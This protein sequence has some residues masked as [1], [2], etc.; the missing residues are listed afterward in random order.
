MSQREHI[1]ENA[2]VMIAGG[3]YRGDVADYAQQV[4]NE[5][6]AAPDQPSAAPEVCVWTRPPE[7]T[8]MEW[9][10][11][12][13]SCGR[14]DLAVDYFGHTH[15]GYCGKPKSFLATDPTSGGHSADPA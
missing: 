6:N 11:W 3:H 2:L 9:P 8:V 14:A 1:A 7:G 12:N 15:C 10:Y 4:L 5:I 13:P